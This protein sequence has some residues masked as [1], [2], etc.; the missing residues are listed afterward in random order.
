[1]KHPEGLMKIIVSVFITVSVIAGPLPAQDTGSSRYEGPI[2]DMHL[3]GY[4]ADDYWGGQTHPTGVASPAT[5][6]E[7]LNQTLAYMERFKIVKGVIDGNTV[8]TIEKHLSDNERFLPGYS[9]WVTL[10]DT[11]RF[12]ELVK[13]GTIKVFGEVASVYRG[14]TLSDPIYEPYLRIC[15]KYGI[16]VA[17]HTGGGPPRT[18]YN[19]CPDFRLSL[20]DPMHI[21]DALIR[22]PNL[23]IYLMHG[24]EVYYEYA[25]RMMKQYPQLYVDLGVLLWVD[26]IVQDYAVRLL[27]L[28]KRVGVLDRIMYGTDQMAWPGAIESAVNFL[29]GMDFLTKEEKAGIFYGNAARFLGLSEE[30][31]ARHNGE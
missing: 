2:I 17:Y 29:N 1:M 16:P 24:G 23:K 20:G 26:P 31:M 28:A 11:A 3:H 25:V 14:R 15:E 19:C 18:P 22:H 13:N 21:E 10:P 7:H 9:D 5:V 8:R 4:N 6:E 30:E 12:E 27:K